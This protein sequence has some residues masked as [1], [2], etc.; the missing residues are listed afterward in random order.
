[1][2]MCE[3]SAGGHPGK[4]REVEDSSRKLGVLFWRMGRGAL[5]DG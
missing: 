5:I 2:Q 4:K 3:M 1:M